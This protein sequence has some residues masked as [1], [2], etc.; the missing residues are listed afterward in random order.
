M[1]H[2]KGPI[3]KHTK[4]LGRKEMLL[5]SMKGK[6]LDVGCGEGELLIKATLLDF[7]IVGVDRSKK[8]LS[9]ALE[10]AE[11][12]N[13]S[14]NVVNASTEELPFEKESF[15]T[16]TMGEVIEH[17]EEPLETIEYLLEFLK[18]NGQL[19][20][21]TPAGFAHADGDHKNFFFTEESLKLLDKYWVFDFLPSMW[22][23]IHKLI[24]I[25]WFL[26]TIKNASASYVEIE[27]GDSK[28]SSLDFFITITKN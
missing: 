14:I 7:D 21:T 28:H 16:I 17:L 13:T 12:S 18:P 19:L 10:T 11:L 24:N 1:K 5:A 26:S 25:D 6:V 15:D 23:R 3:T 2:V 22:L 20:I 27:H 4:L 8:E 9:V